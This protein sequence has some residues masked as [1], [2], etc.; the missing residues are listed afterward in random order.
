MNLN[1]DENDPIK[2]LTLEKSQHRLRRLKNL[3][4][5]GTVELPP[6]NEDQPWDP[7]LDC[8]AICELCRQPWPCESLRIIEQGDEVAI[9]AAL[10]AEEILR[11]A[12]AGINDK[13][14]EVRG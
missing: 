5:K 3:H 13:M 12:K 8:L 6:L 1:P 14:I 2:R 11:R 4:R 9:R 10:P 7:E